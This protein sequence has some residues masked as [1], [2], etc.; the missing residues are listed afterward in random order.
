MTGLGSLNFDPL[1]WKKQGEGSHFC[2]Y[3]E[4]RDD[5]ENMTYDNTDSDTFFANCFQ[6][7]SQP[8]LTT[9]L[10]CKMRCLS[11][12]GFSLWGGKQQNV[13]P[14]DF[15]TKREIWLNIL[16]CAIMI[17]SL[18]LWKKVSLLTKGTLDL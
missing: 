17:V 3:C 7:G 12:G 8:L 15:L 1:G 2:S 18:I 5:K 4:F 6:R 9:C 13:Y 10:F 16:F 11:E 14:E